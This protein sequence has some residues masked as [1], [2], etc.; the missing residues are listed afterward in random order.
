LQILAAVSYD[1]EKRIVCLWNSVKLTGN[2]SRDRRFR[3][4]GPETSASASELFVALVAIAKVA[5][6]SGKAL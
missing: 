1:F 4:Q 3:R 6:D 5:H 2:D